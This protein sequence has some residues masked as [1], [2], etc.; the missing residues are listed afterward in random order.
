[1][2]KVND[3]VDVKKVGEKYRVVNRHDKKVARDEKGSPIDFGGYENEMDARYRARGI[4]SGLTRRGMKY[5][6]RAKQN[7]A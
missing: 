4:N 2:A 6:V 3:P 7:A 5:K 1:M